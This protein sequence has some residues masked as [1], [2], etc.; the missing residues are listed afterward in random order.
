ME[1]QKVDLFKF[2]FKVSDF[3]GGGGGSSASKEVLNMTRRGALYAALAVFFNIFLRSIDDSS[4]SLLHLLSFNG[5]PP[6]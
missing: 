6:S 1:F 5:F 3:S 2:I 4:S